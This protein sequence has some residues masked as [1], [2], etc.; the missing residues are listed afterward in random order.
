MDMFL[1]LSLLFEYY[2]ALL[3]DTQKEI[4]DLY[5]NQ[6]FTLTE[7]AE[8]MGI[9]KQGVRDALKKSEKLLYK[10]EQALSIQ[11]KND[12]LGCLV[13]E[14]TTIIQSATIS[15]KEKTALINVANQINELI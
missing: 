7:I 11:K 13:R 15:E 9:T 10:Y 1:Q 4:C 8:D 6:N 5:Y 14:I 2:G 12:K 3:T